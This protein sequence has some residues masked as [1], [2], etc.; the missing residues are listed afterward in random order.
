MLTR[1]LLHVIEPA[2][3]VDLTCNRRANLDRTIDDVGDP[4]IVSIDHIDYA[5]W[6]ECSGVERLTP[7]RWIERCSI[8]RD[9]KL[10]IG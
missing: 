1:V 5:Y 10:T 9:V 7:G 2:R 3:P 4:T 6:A 8:E